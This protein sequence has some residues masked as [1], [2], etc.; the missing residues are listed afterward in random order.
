MG[1]DTSEENFPA[2]LNLALTAISVFY[3]NGFIPTR[4][5]Y[6]LYGF[7]LVGTGAGITIYL[8]L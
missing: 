7:Q 3:W 8:C 4:T 2:C 5:V 1:I 6:F